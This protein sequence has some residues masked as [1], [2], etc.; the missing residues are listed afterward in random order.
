MKQCRHYN[1][2]GKVKPKTSNT[3]IKLECLPQGTADTV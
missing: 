2:D 3:N 1:I